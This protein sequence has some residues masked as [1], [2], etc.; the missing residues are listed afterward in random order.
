MTTAQLDRISQTTTR[1]LRMTAHLL[2]AEAEGDIIAVRNLTVQLASIE[3]E[4]V[5]IAPGF[6]P[7]PT[8]TPIAVLPVRELVVSAAA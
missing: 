6:T 1:H 2:E 5:L 7:S 3:D 8:P 4:L